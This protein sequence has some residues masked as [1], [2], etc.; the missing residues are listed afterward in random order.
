MAHW[1]YALPV[2]SSLALAMWRYA[3]RAFL[4]IVG[5]LTKDPQ[6]SKQCAEMLRLMRKDAKDLPSYLAISPDFGKFPST[7]TPQATA[8]S[9]PAASPAEETPSLR[10]DGWPTS[11][12]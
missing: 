9:T 6:R 5:G 12:R 4:V 11:P 10:I 1:V 3:P 2:V 7:E 8:H